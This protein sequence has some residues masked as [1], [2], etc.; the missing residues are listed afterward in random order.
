MK[1]HNVMAAL[2]AAPLAA[3]ASVSAGEEAGSRMETTDPSTVP[4]YSI[5]Q[6]VPCGMVRLTEVQ[7]GSVAGLRWAALQVRGNAVV[8]V[9]SR[10]VVPETTRATYR[11][12]AGPAAVRVYQ[13]M[14]VRLDDRCHA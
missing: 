13:G 2:L 1:R 8:G 5:G 11:R 3:C 4:V 14:A 12:M 6:K 7:A 9:R 10:L